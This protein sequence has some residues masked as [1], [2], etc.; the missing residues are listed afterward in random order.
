MFFSKASCVQHFLVK[1]PIY[2]NIFIRTRV[3]GYKLATRTHLSVSKRVSAE[4]TRTVTRRHIDTF[5]TRKL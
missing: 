3:Y 4:I 2:A 5:A 1:L